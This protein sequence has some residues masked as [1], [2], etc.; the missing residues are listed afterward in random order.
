MIN[1]PLTM[2]NGQNFRVQ[3]NELIGCLCDHSIPRR[4]W[5]ILHWIFAVWMDETGKHRMVKFI[6][7]NWFH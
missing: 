6:A 4:L 1:D 3:F 5:I 2:A 7:F